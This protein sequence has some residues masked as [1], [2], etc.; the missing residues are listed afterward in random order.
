MLPFTRILFPVDFSE[1]CAEA[2]PYVSAMARHCEA[3]LTLLHVVDAPPFGYYGMDPAIATA[4]AYAEMMAERRT[5]Y[6]DC[7]LNDKFSAVPVKRVVEHGDAAT[8]ITDYARTNAIQLIM[9]P[10]HGYGVFRRLLLGSVTAK[11]LHDAECPVW[12]CG[13]LEAE[14]TRMPGLYRN[15]LCAVDLTAEGGS[16]IRSAAQFAQ[17][18]GAVLRLVHAIPTSDAMSEQRFRDFGFPQA[19]FDSARDGILKLQKEAGTNAEVC[20]EAGD[21]SKIVGSAALRYAADLVIVGRGRIH[22]T[23]GLLRTHSYAVIRESP[24]PV[25]SICPATVAVSAIDT[26]HARDP[27]PLATC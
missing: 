10:T 7:F 6:L 15:V 2:A 23:L 27:V 13:Q 11:V 17:E 24:S 4:S 1:R 3:H 21:V 9:M 8:V 22:K 16:L 12:T 25:L 14:K 19:L 20:I 18:V 5:K 26:D